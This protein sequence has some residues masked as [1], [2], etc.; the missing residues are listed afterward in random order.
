[1]ASN[2]SRNCSRTVSL[3]ATTAPCT[4]STKEVRSWYSSGGIGRFSAF[5]VNIVSTCS[6]ASDSDFASLLNMS[7][8]D[9]IRNDSAAASGKLLISIRQPVNFAPKRALTPERPI[10]RLSWS[11]GTTTAAVFPFRRSSSRK[12]PE[13]RAG[14][15]AFAINVAESGFHSITSIFSSLRSRTID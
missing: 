2:F 1:M 4:R 11:S 8:V 6:I 3:S 12:T 9:R 14:L 13:T 10:A 15:R 5:L 7:S